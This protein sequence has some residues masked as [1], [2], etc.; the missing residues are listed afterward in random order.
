MPDPDPVS[1][2][3]IEMGLLLEGLYRHHGVDFR[4]Y[5]ATSLKRRIRACMTQEGV[6]TISGLQEKALHDPA[7]V[8]RLA[9]AMTVK[10]TSMFRDPAFYRA[11]RREVVPVLRTYPFLRLWHAGCSTGE[12][13]YGMA[14]LL[15]EEG[16]YSRCRI[17]ATDLDDHVLRTAAAGELPLAA[18]RR[19]AHSY[20]L[21][22]G[23]A[24]FA[25]YYTIRENRALLLPSL[26][27]NIVFGRHNLATETSFN[28]FHV[29]VCR[30]VLIY[31]RRGL[32]ARVHDLLYESLGPLGY[33]GLGSRESIQFTPHEADYEPVAPAER[34]YRKVR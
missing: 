29:V 4:E 1:L 27:R 26:R 23:R 33:L 11:F 19:H 5:A 22:G 2:E 24:A 15:T 16:L 32:Q 21:A 18:L 6:A 28:E 31:F 8:D 12:E 30:N 14:V 34:I 7:C 20:E 10:V 17:Y 13:V 9:T 3:D 25:D